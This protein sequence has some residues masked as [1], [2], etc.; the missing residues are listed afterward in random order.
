[1]A[2]QKLV[3]YPGTFNPFHAGH[4]EAVV[5][6]AHAEP[7]GGRALQPLRR[8]VVCLTADASNPH[9][10]APAPT[11]HR[12]RL[13]QLALVNAGASDY[14]HVS[15][16]E[17]APRD[18]RQLLESEAARHGIDPIHTALMCGDDVLERF[19]PS[20][21]FG[22][23]VF[24]LRR[25]KEVAPLLTRFCN[26]LVAGSPAMEPPS[27]RG[28][29][30]VHHVGHNSRPYSSTAVRWHALRGGTPAP[31]AGLDAGLGALRLGMEAAGEAD[32]GALGERGLTA[33]AWAYVRQHRLYQA[34]GAFTP[35]SPPPIPPE[36]RLWRCERVVERG[37][38]PSCFER[39]D[40][41]DGV[42]SSHRW[43]ERK[44]DGR[45]FVFGAG[46]WAP[47]GIDKAL[48]NCCCTPRGPCNCCG[49]IPQSERDGAVL[50]RSS[51][52]GDRGAIT[53]RLTA[54]AAY[55][56]GTLF[57][58]GGWVIA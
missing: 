16:C 27:S 45:A 7:A 29:S 31:P 4:A 11:K 40:A 43:V 18:L 46:A 49:N 34:H 13:A 26:P 52:A 39:E 51:E 56:N 21:F 54:T 32:I 57:Y 22:Q 14:A 10:P 12:V 23:V 48:V 5:A 15:C 1:M 19:P 53:V 25:N 36:M 50:L 55:I 28:W 41:A 17:G 44:A 38:L 3:I 47:S 42:A 30:V 2:D 6:A 24:M 35:I 37:E 8:V 33:D 9:K 58:A 20:S